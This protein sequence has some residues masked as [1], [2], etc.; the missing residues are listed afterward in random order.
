MSRPKKN[1]ADYFSHDTGMRNDPK[2]L[3]LR[4]NHG[5]IG[6]AIWN[7]LLET[8][9]N[10]DNFEI[11]LK[12]DLQWEIIA[13]DFRID[14]ETLKI[15]IDFSC[16]IGLLDVK[17][18]IYSS[19]NLKERLQPVLDARIRKREWANKRLGTQRMKEVFIEIPINDKDEFDLDKQK[20][21]AE[22][23]KKIDDIK[24]KLKEDY[25]RIINSK[26]EVIKNE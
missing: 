23:Y 18:Y 26:V 7:M 14:T 12:T 16:K 20:E 10:S 9:T 4:N 19:K 15:I 3:S 22:K 25:E 24:T 11:E 2:I 21:I 5:Y 1:N 6:Y 8:L 13:G 17:N